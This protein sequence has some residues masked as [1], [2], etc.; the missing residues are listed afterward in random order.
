[1]EILNFLIIYP[2]FMSLFWMVGTIIYIFFSE[3]WLTQKPNKE[4]GDEGISFLIPCFNEEETIKATIKNL[5]A[6]DFPNKQIIVIN[7]GST[8]NSAKIIYELQK[9]LDFT[10]IDLEFNNGKANALN[11]GI[12]YAKYDYVMG[13]DADTLIDDNAP[14]FMI[15]H[16]KKNP[17]LAAVT[18]NPR[19]RNKKSILGKIQTIEY[20]SMVGSIKRT[21]AL[22][23]KINTISGVFTLFRKSAIEKV[24][25]W[26][27]DMITE[28]IAISWKFHLAGLH[29][30]YEPRALCRMLVPETIP[31]LWKQRLRWA[32][33]GQEVVIR[34][35]K[36]G[37]KSFNL[38]MYFLIFEQIF[39]LIWIYS[40]LLVLIFNIINANL[41]DYYFLKYKLS[42]LVL[43]ALI[44]TFLNAVQF[45]IA[46]IADSKYEK[47]NI[48]TIVYLSWYST[49][50]WVIN[51]LVSSLAFPKA[52]RR[53]K[54]E[55]ATWTS[56]DRG[57]D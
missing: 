12:D 43:S 17:K 41:L 11:K 42:L 49:V 23:G 51:A 30:K 22:T 14:Y 25:K 28:D 38:A 20:A 48:F 52:I 21:Q 50:Y 1:M 15:E 9:Y 27:I 45:T 56:P 6:L 46:L 16:F 19:I 32:Q 39:S 53:K 24:G 10:F 8:D 2:L 3:L 26:D 36:K 35:L 18:G 37:L 4:I 34:D 55:F 54:G 33:G 31:G 7:D 57:K 47:I 13:I 29:I 40:V 44:L 5:L